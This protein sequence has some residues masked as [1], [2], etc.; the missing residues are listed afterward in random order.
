MCKRSLEAGAGNIDDLPEHAPVRRFLPHLGGGKKVNHDGKKATECASSGQELR[1]PAN[2]AFVTFNNAMD[3]SHVLNDVK[4][5]KEKGILYGEYAPE[6]APE[7]DDIIFENLQ[8]GKS[9]RSELFRRNYLIIFG[10]LILTGSVTTLVRLSYYKQESRR[11][12]KGNYEY[13]ANIGIKAWR[14][15]RCGDVSRGYIRERLSVAGVILACNAFVSFVNLLLKF[16]IRLRVK[17]EKHE[18]VSKAAVSEMRAVFLA[19]YINTSVLVGMFGGPNILVKE[20]GS[21]LGKE[22]YLDNGT[23]V[24]TVCLINSIADEIEV[25]LRM[26]KKEWDKR[27]HSART[28]QELTEAY[29]YM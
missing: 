11:D 13:C 22:W 10:V 12:Q 25:R 23:S 17:T 8:V 14:D 16:V 27:Y 29:R 19:Q 9:Q 6:Y 24:F 4:K 7:P 15:D 1:M 5:K 28:Q 18:T 20:F 21:L 26:L 3:C 2:C